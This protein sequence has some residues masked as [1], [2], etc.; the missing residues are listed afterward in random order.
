MESPESINSLLGALRGFLLTSP[1]MNLVTQVVPGIIGYHVRI[2]LGF[3]GSTICQPSKGTIP[4]II[5]IILIP[6]EE[7][8]LYAEHWHAWPLQA[9]DL[10]TARSHLSVQ[11]SALVGQSQSVHGHSII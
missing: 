5:I 10:T 2:G 3:Q 8:W 9:P 6:Q 1:Q 4:Q 7:P 11:R